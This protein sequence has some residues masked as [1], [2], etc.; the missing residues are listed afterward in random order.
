MS[1]NYKRAIPD[2]G[3]P[4]YIMD[5]ISVVRKDFGQVYVNV[6]QVDTPFMACVSKSR[7]KLIPTRHWVEI[8]SEP[9]DPGEP[10]YANPC[11]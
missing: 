5:T 1:L 3:I 6:Y 11:D 7:K 9:I 4:K 2:S 8:S 10:P